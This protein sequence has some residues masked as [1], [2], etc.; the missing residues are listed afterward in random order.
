MALS[1]HLRSL[2]QTLSV[3]TD[4]IDQIVQILTTDHLDLGCAVIENVAS[5]KVH[6]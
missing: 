4:R 5:E 1:T 3:T 2:L 6:N